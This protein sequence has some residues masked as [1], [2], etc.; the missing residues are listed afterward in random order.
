MEEKKD[1]EKQCD[2]TQ[3]F[4]N[5]KY[6]A[7]VLLGPTA[8]GK[9]KLANRLAEHFSSHLISADSRQVYRGLDIGS[10][11]DLSEIS[12]P[13]HLLD[14]ASLEQEYSVY[15][16]Q[17]DF[18]N[19]FAELK[20]KKIKP[21]VVGGTGMYLDAIIRDYTLVEVPTNIALRESLNGKTMEELVTI[22]ISL[23]GS[24]HNKTD[25]EERHRL[26]RAIEIET[27]YKEKKISPFDSQINVENKKTQESKKRTSFNP[28]ILG[29]TFPRD[30]LRHNITM[31]LEKR[32]EEGMVEEVEGLL[33]IGFS[34]ERLQRLGLEYKFLSLYLLKEISKQELFQKLN[35]AIHQFAKRQETWFRGMERK[36]V[37]IHWIRC[38]GSEKDCSVE[39][40]FQKALEI[41]N[42]EL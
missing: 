11:K 17:R 8:V 19:V 12:V 27:Y 29:T 16:Y 42:A 1:T 6:N 15:D 20:A 21:I 36:G 39:E 35:T 5:S 13:H 26:L 10:G 38:D 31:R 32:I 22:L 4:K 7:I 9:T 41:M 34:H 23:K 40:R 2:K 24:L 18:Y 28:F 3:E 30:I 25:I 37:S 33:Q 14:I